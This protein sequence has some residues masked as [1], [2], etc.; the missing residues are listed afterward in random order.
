MRVRHGLAARTVVPVLPH[1][2]PRALAAK[3]QSWTDDWQPRTAEE[4]DLVSHGA[5]LAWQIDRAE[6]FETAHLSHRVRRPQRRAASAPDPERLQDVANLGSKLLGY[7]YTGSR[8][9]VL[10]R[11]QATAEGCRWLLDR[12]R[13]IELLQ[14]QGSPAEKADMYRWL[15]LLG[16]QLEDA[17]TEP[18]ANAVLVAWNV[19]KPG[20]AQEVWKYIKD[21]LPPHTLAY[22]T[23]AKWRELGPRPADA[24]EALSILATLRKQEVDRLTT[25]LAGHEQFAQEDQ[26]DLA[27]RM[28][29]DPGPGFE[30]HRRYRTAPGRELL[31][32]L[33]ILR[34]LR[35]DGPQTDAAGSD[36]DRDLEPAETDTLRVLAHGVEEAT[37]A[38]EGEENDMADSPDTDNGPEKAPNKAKV[39]SPEDDDRKDVVSENALYDSGEESQFS[40]SGGSQSSS[41]NDEGSRAQSRRPL[42]CLEAS[43]RPAAV[44]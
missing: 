41:R 36:S 8:A 40:G 42:E 14:G 28:A 34:K 10:A 5:R 35:K 16:K 44:P 13:E 19:L 26:V 33:E 11:L 27:D 25:L 18:A 12:W 20:I 17:I 3:I 32:T 15:Y 21:V 9:V 43:Q 2:D 24:A 31:R 30:R 7:A 29:F 1:E 4:A 39:V 38:G 23:M 37:A 22:L 6:R